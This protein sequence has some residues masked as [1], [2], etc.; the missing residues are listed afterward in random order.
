MV[1][2]WLSIVVVTM[3]TIF[4]L[5]VGPGAWTVQAKAYDTPC[6]PV[7][8]TSS[9]GAVFPHDQNYRGSL[10]E[11]HVRPAFP[12]VG[13]ARPRSSPTGGKWLAAADGGV[14]SFGNVD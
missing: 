7:T 6:F 10:Q 5:T 4:A 1:W 8:F 12:I 13:I 3:V 9:D 2:R 11:M 14:F